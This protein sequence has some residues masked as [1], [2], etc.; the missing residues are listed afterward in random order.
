MNTEATGNHFLSRGSRGP[1]AAVL[2]GMLMFSSLHSSPAMG[3]TQ[4][5]PPDETSVEADSVSITMKKLRA[6]AAARDLQ[7]YYLKEVMRD[8]GAPSMALI[9]DRKSMSEQFYLTNSYLGPYTLDRV[10]SE[11]VILSDPE[12]QKFYHLKL[13]TPEMVEV[14]GYVRSVET[15]TADSDPIDSDLLSSAS[16]GENQ[17]GTVEPSADSQ[18][19][20][21]KGSVQSPATISSAMSGVQVKAPAQAKSGGSFLSRLRRA[22]RIKAQ[23]GTEGSQPETDQPTASQNSTPEGSEGA[24]GAESGE[25][26]FDID[27]SRGAETPAEE[28]DANKKADSDSKGNSS[29][30]DALLNFK[31]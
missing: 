18:S 30:V 7:R 3:S 20:S 26:Q 4:L 8:N 1:L 5:Q 2:F 13:N 10:M 11:G 14:Q 27:L 12:T 21:S 17:S 31:P 25:L 19:A 23:E 6:K 9:L 24:A 22:A 29:T 28:A 15:K 16:S